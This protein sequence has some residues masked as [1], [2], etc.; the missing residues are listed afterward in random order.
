MSFSTQ[1]EPWALQGPI[2]S[3]PDPNAPGMEPGYRYFATDVGP[4]TE[5]VVVRGG[6]GNSWKTTGGG[7][8]GSGP[9]LAI[10]YFDAGGA[11][12][13]DPALTPLGT[14]Y[15][16]PQIHD[17]RQ[18]VPPPLGGN[19]GPNVVWRQ[20]ASSADGDAI[21]L[22]GIDGWI[23]KGAQL[24]STVGSLVRKLRRAGVSANG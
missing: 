8:G 15:G 10:G 16:R 11:L 2:A 5:Y 12:T 21:D 4:G 9:P 22:E 20:G 18:Q 14:S 24:S 13:G 1:D 3:R 7:G 6:L 17:T 23:A 19:L